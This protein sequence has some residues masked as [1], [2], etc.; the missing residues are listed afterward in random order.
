M[1]MTP[2][3]GRTPS[4]KSR[5]V[6]LLS[7]REHSRQEL[8]RKLQ[9]HSEMPGDIEAVLDELERAGWQSDARFAQ[10]LVQRKAHKQGAARIL[11]EL[12]QHGIP[13]EQMVELREALRGSELPRACEVWQRRFGGELPQAPADYARQARFLAGRGFSHDVVKKILAGGCPSDS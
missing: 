7:R 9:P 13:A 11:D 3:S 10:G 2:K 4:L 8:L 1:G 5:A 6:A 12:R